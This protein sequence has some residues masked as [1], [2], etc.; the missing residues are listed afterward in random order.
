MEK[1]VYIK[2]VDILCGDLMKSIVRY[3]IPVILVGLAQNL[4]HAVDLMVLGTMADTNAIASVG[5]TTL[6]IQLLVNTFFGF[7]SGTKIVLARLVGASEDEQVRRT[8]S[9][10]M[11]LGG[12]LGCATAIGGFLLAPVLLRATGCPTECFDGAVLYTRIY[13]AAAP[14]IMLYNFGSAILSSSGD[15]QRPLIYMLLSGGTNVVLNVILCLI[16]PQKVTAVAIATAVSQIVGAILV[17]LRLLHIKG[18]CRLSL[19]KLQWSNSAFGNL[20]ANGA[21][22]ALYNALHPLSG[23]QIQ[24]QIN[25]F[26]AAVIAGKSAAL[27]IEGL[28]EPVASSAWAS[29]A[30][31]FVGQNIGASKTDRVKKSILYPLFIST[32]LGLLLGVLTTV[33][34]RPLL[35]LYVSEEAAILAAHIRIKYAVLPYAIACINGVLAHVIQ[36]FG[37]SAFCTVNSVVSVL[38]FRVFWMNLI[39]PLCPTFGV[40]CQCNLV[41]WMLML[42]ANV[43]FTLYLYKRKFQKGRLKKFT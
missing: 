1:K 16:M 25:S 13:L 40:I 31:V 42:T 10:A 6:L 21:P 3:C 43:T 32:S 14:A 2:N 18:A 38:L 19:R 8:G 28:I 41:S 24:S 15:S 27:S 22:L 17:L 29:T 23:L 36:A 39:Y 37:Y 4:F 34:S 9:T 12:I 35:S 5:A 11:L 26:G 30:T 33:F 7:M 20:M